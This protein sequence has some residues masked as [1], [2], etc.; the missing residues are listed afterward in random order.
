MST[1]T[2]IVIAF[3]LSMDAFA[4][5]CI[6]GLCSLEHHVKYAWKVGIYFGFF[7]GFMT[8]VGWLFGHILKDS[9]STFDHWI[10]LIIL[11]AIGVKMIYESVKNQEVSCDV[12]NV[13]SHRSLIMFAIATSIDALAIGTGF[14]IL[15]INITSTAL[16]I[17]LITFA[18]SFI[19]VQVGR[20]FGHLVG[21][22]AEM[23]G[24]TLL[25]LIGIKI[26]IEHLPV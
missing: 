7:Q 2:L 26:F 11:S 22:K 20:R 16:I 10:A 18:L 25:I 14:A 5:A 9:I 12:K 15:N 8:F 3:G 13:D 17:G 23:I 21:N 19:G 24:G 4:V 1:L 6:N